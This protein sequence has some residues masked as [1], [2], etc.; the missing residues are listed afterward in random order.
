MMVL[1]SGTDATIFDL[2]TTFFQPVEHKAML[3][4]NI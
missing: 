1:L 4:V 3:L 2:Q